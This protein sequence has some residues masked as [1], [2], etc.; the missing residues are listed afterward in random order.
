MAADSE[1][2]VQLEIGHVL[3]VDIVG[4][5]KLLIT[6]QR[7]QVQALKEIVRSTKQF[8]ASDAS[9]MLVRI[10]T[11]DGMALIFRDSVE[12]PV[13]CALEISRAVKT[14]PAIHLRMGIHSGPVSEVTD[15]NDRANIAGAGIDTAQ[16]VMDCGDTGHILLSKHVADD[17]AP[18]PRWNPYLHD[19]GECEVKH[20]RKI[21]LVNFYTDELGNPT[22]PEK[23]NGIC[24]QLVETAAQGGWWRSARIISL[25][26]ACLVAIIAVIMLLP[27][28]GT[29]LASALMGRSPAP[30]KQPSAA[31]KSIAILP[32]VDLSQ[33]KDQEYFC[34]GIS[35]EILDALA[36]VQGLRVVARTSSFSFKGKNPDVSEIA[37]KLNVR[38]VLEGSL[39]REG[40]RIRITAQLIN[41]RDG[42]DIWSETFERELQGVF[43]VQDEIT[44]SIV[45]ALKIKLAVAPSA[46]GQQNTE[47]YD[48]YLRGLYLS[49]KSDEESLRQSLT[50]FQRALEKD[51]NLSRAWTGIARAWLYLADAY[52]RP[53]EAYPRVKEAASKVLALDERDAEAHCYLGEV[54]RVLDRDVAGEEAEVNLALQLDPNS[55]AAHLF[56]GNGVHATRGELEKAVVEIQEARKLDPLSPALGSWAAAVYLANGQ[57]DDAITEAERTLQL[58]PNYMYRDPILATAYR[59]KGDYERAIALYKKAE[60][61]TGIPQAGLAITYAKMGRQSDARRTLDEAQKTLYDEICCRRCDREHLRRSRRKR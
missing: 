52:V 59:E 5:S 4:Y 31:E 6:E 47:A 32:F 8:R 43:A 19:L 54:R 49:N 16:R 46:Q 51:P 45:D 30:V 21:F 60:E 10:P 48:L 26:S 24:R 42:F 56:L 34:D 41:A 50:W 58:D 23:L 38:N 2:D 7:Q 29:N 33:A 17:L 15:V 57:I 28:R 35:E 1:P 61:S 9:G 14:R 18:Y 40:N 13:R 11:G 27:R 53:L 55:A 36:K 22:V 25:L 39:R 3:L 37:Q 44:R 12:A 20:G